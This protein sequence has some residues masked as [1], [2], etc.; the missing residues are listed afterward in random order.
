MA[1]INISQPIKGEANI[2]FSILSIP[3]T[4]VAA[5]TKTRSL[6][7]N[8]CIFP[9][10]I[11]SFCYLPS[12]TIGIRYKISIIVVIGAGHCLVLLFGDKAY[13]F[14]AIM[15]FLNEVS[16]PTLKRAI[17]DSISLSI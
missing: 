4:Y 17:A 3:E 7:P 10:W 1:S 2:P 12:I 15:G 6:T 13:L 9:L 14:T 8:Y 5:A 16:R 11:F